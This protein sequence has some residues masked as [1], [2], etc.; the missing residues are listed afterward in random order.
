MGRVV[1]IKTSIL[2]LFLFSNIMIKVPKSFFNAINT[3][4]KHFISQ[5]KK[6]RLKIQALQLDV[7]EGGLSLPNFKVYYQASLLNWL[8]FKCYVKRLR[9]RPL[10]IF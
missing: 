2:P 8:T 9:D 4:I 3:E 10:Y 1:L 6:Q 5:G 7:D